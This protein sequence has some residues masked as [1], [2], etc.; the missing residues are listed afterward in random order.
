ML[1]LLKQTVTEPLW[2]FGDICAERRQ[3]LMAPFDFGGIIEAIRSE[4][5]NIRYEKDKGTHEAKGSWRPIFR[6]DVCEETFD[7]FF[8]SPYGYRGQY[9][10]DPEE[11]RKKNSM[12]VSALI[13][14]LV[15][16]IRGELQ[17]L[18]QIRLSLASAHAKIWIEEDQHNPKTPDLI[19]EIRVSDWEAAARAVHGRLAHGDPTLTTKEVDRIFG[20]RA[21]VG[22]TLKV[23]GA[24]VAPDG[25]LGVVA[26]KLRRAE[27]IKAYGVS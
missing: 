8:N 18:N 14:T 4:A 21:P 27:E 22:R 2:D 9:L 19:V 10:A 26:S 12:L 5:R 15:H 23:M 25:C 17:L 16:S 6:F 1:N 20:I 7:R 13:D 3:S 11:G 24:W